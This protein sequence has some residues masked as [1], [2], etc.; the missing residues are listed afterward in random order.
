MLNSTTLL[1][2]HTSTAKCCKTL[3]YNPERFWNSKTIME[4]WTPINSEYNPKVQLFGGGKMVTNTKI[5]QNVEKPSP[6]ILES[7][8]LTQP[9][10]GSLA[11]CLYVCCK[12]VWRKRYLK[13]R[14]PVTHDLYKEK[15][16]QKDYSFGVSFQQIWNTFS[17][18]L[19]GGRP[20]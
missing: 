6:H 9:C 19:N 12:E 3:N 7:K 10:S 18:G 8:I 2:T 4:T 13:K 1:I 14:C 11:N 16:K 17:P 20:L 5:T 15:K